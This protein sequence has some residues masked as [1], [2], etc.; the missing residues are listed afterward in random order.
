M[1]DLKKQQH[2]RK[3]TV[4]AQM[5][6]Y[7]QSTEANQRLTAI[8]WQLITLNYTLITINCSTNEEWAEIL[9]CAVQ[10]RNLSVYCHVICTNRNP[11]TANDNWSPSIFA[12]AKSGDVWCF[13][14]TSI[15][16]K[17][18]MSCIIFSYKAKACWRLAD[19][20]RVEQT[21]QHQG[22]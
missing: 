17:P 6:Q 19:F 8:F 12:L 2:N 10:G 9:S 20:L 18:V 22:L 11:E 21:L 7:E 3:T 4:L 14:L 15:F 13:T 5:L 16:A 1:R